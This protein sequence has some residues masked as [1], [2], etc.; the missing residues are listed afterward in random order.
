MQD[1]VDYGHEVRFGVVMYGGVSLAIYINGVAAELYRMAR[2]TPP[3][4]VAAPRDGPPD[5]AEIYRRLAWLANN[6]GLRQRY[7]ERIRARSDSSG[8]TPPDAWD[9]ADLADGT[10]A[11]LVVDVISGTSAGGINGIF[12]AKALACDADF[13]QLERLWIEEG[14]FGLL[15]NDDASYKGLPSGTQRGGPPRSLLNSDRMYL[16]LLDALAAMQKNA[17]GRPITDEL[18]L[19]VTTT[20]IEGSPVALRLADRVVTERRHKHNYRF[21]LPEGSTDAADFHRDNDPF[22]A[23]AARCTSSFPFAFEPMTVGALQRLAVRDPAQLDAWDR[24]FVSFPPEMVAARENRQRAFGDGGYLDNKPFSYAVEALSQRYATRT[25]ERKLLYVEPAPEDIR[26]VPGAGGEVPDP[27]SNAL[28]AL[29]G[30]PRYETIREDLQAVLQRNRRIERIERILRLAD[31]PYDEDEVFKGVVLRDGRV[32]T[33]GSLTLDEM[34]QYYGHAFEP[35]WRLRVYAV[36]DELAERLAVRLGIDLGSDDIYALRAL[37]RVWREQRFSDNGIAGRPDTTLNAFLNGFD[38]DYRLRRIGF[39]LRKVNELRRLYREGWRGDATWSEADRALS[40][41]VPAYRPLSSLLPHDRETACEA[42]SALQRELADTRAALLRARRIQQAPQPAYL[43]DAALRAELRVLFDVVLGKADAGV[44]PFA[45]DPAVLRKAAGQRVLQDAVFIRAR[46]VYERAEG[47]PATQA[48][49][50]LEAEMESMRFKRSDDGEGPPFQAI[51]SRAWRV[52]GSPR[53]GVEGDA[54]TLVVDP[55][56][57]PEHLDHGIALATDVGYHIRRLLSDYYLRFDT[58][59]QM[60]FPLYY[61][62]GTG[63]PCTVDVIRVSPIDAT[64]L[65]SAEAQQNNPKLAGTRLANFGGFLDAQWRRNDILWGRLDG[66]ERIVHAVLP[67]DDE[68]TRAIRGEL[69]DLAHAAILR[70][71]LLPRGDAELTQR[72]LALGDATMP[73]QDQAAFRQKVLALVGASS[74]RNL[75]QQRRNDPEP[76]PAAT[77]KSLA[78]AVTVTGR[79]L[80]GVSRGPAIAAPARWIARLGLV[81]QGLVALA[82]PRTLLHEGW[83]AFVLVLYGLE[84]LLLVLA[85]VLGSQDMRVL[86]VTA[87]GVTA[88]VHIAVAIL[89]DVVRGRSFWRRVLVTG[90]TLAVL[91]GAAVGWAQLLGLR[92][93]G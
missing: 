57:F 36:T 34:L 26:S 16:K 79:L 72:M 17:S 22:L 61:D 50:I 24:F 56:G 43:L 70:E 1:P 32:P 85:L 27:V 40:E 90:V 55:R 6:P 74:L 48:Q 78:R 11:R 81:L 52:L 77:M 30:I 3:A 23:F 54:V 25:V 49:R 80:E 68:D 71:S 21:S 75:V 91:G 69:I 2:M 87:L 60:G 14:D 51:A 42:L 73:P 64:R 83:R 44:L 46:H 31:Q 67:M 47:V 28:A 38:F 93:P 86:A 18:D 82:I 89:Q 29:T 66:A 10:P 33:W 15:I 63:E 37:V 59:D 88:A 9:E 8:N 19:Y 58:H 65:R 4:G 13:G 53:L 41:R 20:D 62:T 84:A 5:S 45:L 12:L 92:L 39:I 35:Y 7:A 76:P